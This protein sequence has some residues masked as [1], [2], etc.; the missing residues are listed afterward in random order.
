M[1]RT[2]FSLIGCLLAAATA[3]TLATASANKRPV[4]LKV[5]RA[6]ARRAPEH[7]AYL[8]TWLPRKY[9]Y[10]AWA[11]PLQMIGTGPDRVIKTL[12]IHFTASFPC[13]GRRWCSDYPDLTFGVSTVCQ[14][15]IKVEKTFRFGA[16]TVSWG[17]LFG[18]PQ[19]WRCIRSGGNRTLISTFSPSVSEHGPPPRALAHF[20]ASARLAHRNK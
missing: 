18:T 14:T 16:I 12:E 5:E 2:T 11:Y 19:A 9:F 7:L 1:K 8:P 10:V 4:P 20:V 6:I 3:A 13:P 15:A 17:R